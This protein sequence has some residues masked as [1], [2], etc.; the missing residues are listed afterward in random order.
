MASLL[1]P[2]RSVARDLAI[3]VTLNKTTAAV[4]AR[5]TGL[6]YWR[7]AGIISGRAEP[8]DDEAGRI[9]AAIYDEQVPA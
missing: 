6:P 1:D 4:I 2:P 9:L 8:R 3:L 5:R 7:V